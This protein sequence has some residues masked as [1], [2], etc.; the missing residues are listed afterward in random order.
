MILTNKNQKKIVKYV[1]QKLKESV[2]NCT[3]TDLSSTYVP[4]YDS[5][6]D[7][8]SKSNLAEI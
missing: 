7:E 6:L 2:A 1:I 8:E 4:F 5:I 3:Y